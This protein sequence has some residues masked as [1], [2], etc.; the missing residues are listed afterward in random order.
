MPAADRPAKHGA[1]D[2]PEL[3]KQ[4]GRGHRRL[5]PGRTHGAGR[6][7]GRAR[8][9]RCHWSAR[10]ARRHRTTGGDGY[11]RPDGSGR[12]DRPGRIGLGERHHPRRDEHVPKRS[13]ARGQPTH[14]LSG[15]LGDRWRGTYPRSVTGLRDRNRAV[16]V[17][18][19]TRR[20]P[21]GPCTSCPPSSRRTSPT[22]S[23]WSASP[24]VGDHVTG[25]RCGG[26]DVERID[27]RVH[28]NGRLAIGG[29]AAGG[30][31]CRAPR[32]RGQARRAG[33]RPGPRHRAVQ[34]RGR[35]R[36]Q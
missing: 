12:T 35:S 2:E 18:R 8:A 24:D 13:R 21:A 1:D 10:S 6:V 25:D 9:G 16:P 14:R 4:R 29:G 33:R 17:D 36:A 11:Q 19:S 34:R 26:A 5:G 30:R 28:G 32:R 22:S 20:R 7:P 3:W 27:A 15:R 31:R 23:S